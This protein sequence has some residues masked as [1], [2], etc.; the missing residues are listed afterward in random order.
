MKKFTDQDA[1][2]L[3]QGA[4]DLA[5]TTATDGSDVKPLV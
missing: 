4:V 1:A 2:D 5:K 3:V